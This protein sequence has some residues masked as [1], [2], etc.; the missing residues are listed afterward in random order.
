MFGKSAIHPRQVPILHEVFTP[1][2]RE[3]EWAHAVLSAFTAAGGAACRLPD[4]EMVDRP[5]ADRARRLLELAE[6]WLG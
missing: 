4:G 2:G 1:S 3:L 5:V 6:T